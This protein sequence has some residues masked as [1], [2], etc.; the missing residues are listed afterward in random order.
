MHKAALPP[1]PKF[2]AEYMRRESANRE[3]HAVCRSPLTFTA[4]VTLS[5]GDNSIAAPLFASPSSR[6]TA[7][8]VPAHSLFENWS[9]I[10]RWCLFWKSFVSCEAEDEG[11]KFGSERNKKQNGL[12]RICVIDQIWLLVKGERKHEALRSGL[13]ILSAVRYDWN[14]GKENAVIII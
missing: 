1:K 13:S 14:Y 7:P 8:R 4:H 9:V 12:C 2:H 3:T 10:G 6:R 11:R 5:R